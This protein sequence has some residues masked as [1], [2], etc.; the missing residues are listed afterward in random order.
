MHQRTTEYNG[1]SLAFLS[2][3]DPAR[4]ALLLL[5][6]WPQS[7]EVYDQVVDPLAA[8]HF[9]LA[10]DL[11]AIGDSRGAP[12]SAQKKDLADILIGAAEHVGAR[13][14]VVAG[15]DVGGMIAF[16]AARDHG[17]R[18]IG[19]V[20]MNTVIPGI[21]PWSK[22]LSDP[23]IWHFAFH[24][25]PDLPELLVSGHQ[26]A[27]FDFFT[28]F[29][30]GRKDAVSERHRAT[31]ARAYGRREALEAGF[32]WYRA[33]QADAERNGQAKPFDTP[34]LYLRGDAD[35][36]SPEDYLP[37]LRKAGATRLRGGTLAGSGEFAPLEVPQAFMQAL[38]SFARS[39]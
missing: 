22:I 11:P 4:P 6:G 21:D 1:L 10:F 31:F 37:G 29:L 16:A 34:V 7:K 32:D 26:R 35:G 23:R 28:D 18:I 2:A 14:I 27:Y 20:V 5:H 17:Q 24:A 13:S 9:V 39:C 36:R 30:A 19:S 25:L 3:G 38:L 12:P 33:M 15:F 8:E